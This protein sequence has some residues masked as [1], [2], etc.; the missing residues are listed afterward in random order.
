MSTRTSEGTASALAL[1]SRIDHLPG[2]AR[3]DVG[4]SPYLLSRH[5]FA[6]IDTEFAREGGMAVSNANTM[7]LGR[8]PM[9]QRG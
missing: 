8:A 1:L 3:P 5:R 9:E 7:P 4:L 6:R 2:S